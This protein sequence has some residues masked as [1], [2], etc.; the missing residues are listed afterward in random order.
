[1]RI[2]VSDKSSYSILTTF[3]NIPEDCNLE[4]VATLLL[5]FCSNSLNHEILSNNI[6]LPFKDEWQT[7]LFKDPVRTA[8]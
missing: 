2:T 6:I 7:A 5:F 4:N 1:M 3:R 8:L